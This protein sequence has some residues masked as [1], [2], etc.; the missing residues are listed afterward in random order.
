MPLD[1]SHPAERL[2]G[3]VEDAAPSGHGRRPWLAAAR[4]RRGEVIVLA[5]LEEAVGGPS[6]LAPA[7]AVTRTSSPTSSSPPAPPGSPRASRCPGSPSPTSSAS[8]MHTPGLSEDDRLLAITTTSFD[9]AGLELFLPLAVGATV[10]IADHETARD[11]SLLR[12]RLEGDTITVMQA[13]PATWR[14]LL[15]AGWRGD[16][17][18][19]MLCGGEALSPALAD[20]LLAAGGELWNMYGP[21]ETTVWS[22][23]E[24]IRQ[25]LRPDHHRPAHRRHPGLRPRRGARTPCPAGAEGEI[26]IGGLGLA[27][28]YRGRPELT[29]ERFVQNP[30]GPAGDRIYR[31]GDL[32]RLL[33]DGRIECLGRLDHQVKIRGFRVELGEIETVLRAVPGVKEA[34]VVADPGPRGRPAAGRLLGGRGRARG[35]HRRGPAEA[36]RLHG[37]GRVRAPGGLPPQHQ[38]QDRPQAPAPPEAAQP[39]AGAPVRRP[40]NDTE[41]RIAAVWRDVLGLPEVPV[42]QSFFT[43]GG[44]SLLAVQAVVAAQ[45]RGRD[46]R[47]PSRRSSRPPPWKGL[48]ASVGHSISPT[49]PI[50]VHLR[51]GLHRATAALLPL[52]RPDLPGAGAR[53]PGR[54]ARSSGCTCPSPTCRGAIRARASRRWRGATWS[55]SAVTRRTAPITSSASASAASW[56]TRWPASSRPRARRWPRSPSSTPSFPAALA[57]IARR[58]LCSRLRRALQPR[59]LGRWIGR[60]WRRFA[61][62]FAGRRSGSAA[63]PRRVRRRPIDLPVDGPEVVEEISRFAARAGQ[64][65]G[66]RCWWCAPRPSPPRAGWRWRRTRAGSAARSGSRCTRSRPRT[67][68]SCASRTCARWRGPSPPSS[69]R[70]LAA[71][72]APAHAAKRSSVRSTSSGSTRKS[73]PSAL[74]TTK[75]KCWPSRSVRCL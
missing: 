36:P 26:F 74:P 56:P 3:I 55:S 11:P 52:R 15:E 10:V 43:I 2:R 34:L 5:D 41:T 44:T 33:P 66:A 31:T 13:T 25:R 18:L 60:R 69:E 58:R 38:R 39:A 27:R 65:P 50:V 72:P 9:I 61:S 1:P 19:K 12:R 45:G 64:A 7:G 71:R 17:K 47:S 29:A 68:T 51:A 24:R 20:R 21:T 35:P 22:T 42:D 4:R 48:A 16:G 75:P 67:S 14:M 40:R 6:A 63:R 73:R 23:L 8:M 37:A 70:P 28:G 62:Q 57:S 30:R 49:A 54:T 46:R 53:P 59:E 32:G